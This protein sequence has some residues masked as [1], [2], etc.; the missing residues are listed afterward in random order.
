MGVAASSWTAGMLVALTALIAAYTDR[1]TVRVRLTATAV[2][3]DPTIAPDV[4]RDGVSLAMVAVLVANAL[5]LLLAGLCLF[6]VLRGRR[7]AR[8]ACAAG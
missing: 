3:D 5:L 7:A 8:P 1:E 2:A 6:L 4:L